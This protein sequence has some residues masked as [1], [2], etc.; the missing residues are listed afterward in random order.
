MSYTTNQLAIIIRELECIDCLHPATG[1]ARDEVI[2]WVYDQ[3]ASMGRPRYVPKD[4][5]QDQVFEEIEHRIVMLAA[6]QSYDSGTVSRCNRALGI[7]C[8]NAC[9][10][11]EWLAEEDGRAEKN[12]Q[13]IS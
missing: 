1:K 6:V 13:V 11:Q 7:L 4:W 9:T 12:R 10:V 5:E 3:H 2:K 8:D